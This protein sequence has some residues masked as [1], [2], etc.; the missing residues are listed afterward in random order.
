MAALH[1]GIL[2]AVITP[3]HSDG[4]VDLDRLRLLTDFLIEAGVHG[5]FI[6]GTAGES[7]L[8][9]PAERAAVAAAV[10]E[11]VRGRVPVMV[12]CG[13]ADTP[14]SVE[15]ARQAVA[16]G[17]D[18]ISCVT[19][20]Y[21]RHTD[22]ALYRHFA[23]VAEAVTGTEMYLYNNPELAG[24][25]VSL[26]LFRRLM[27]AYPHVRGIKDTGDSIARLSEYLTLEAHSPQVYTGNN[28]LV[29]P[30]LS[31]GAVGA[32]S[33]LAGALPELYVSLWAA[34]SRG[35]WDR[36]REL[37]SGATRLQQ[38]L[39]GLPYPA[40]LKWLLRRRGIP[41]AGVRPPNQDLDPEQGR[42]LK[43]ALDALGSLGDWLATVG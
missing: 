27:E 37:Q 26:G 33:S 28:M 40:G 12:H 21:Y 7:V 5:L 17:C 8:L 36:A 4:S 18:T 42:G 2:P 41:V 34:W 20:F 10:V 35:E 14:T 32:V 31:I 16:A 23:E 13:A 30:A 19:P 15:L 43:Q 25:G 11:H 6:M 22:E 1:G 24:N 39:R 38:Y 3:F 29:M 9:Q